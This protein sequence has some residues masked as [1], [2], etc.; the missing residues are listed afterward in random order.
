MTK[1]RT[2]SSRALRCIFVLASWSFFGYWPAQIVAAIICL[3][4]GGLAEGV[5]IYPYDPPVTNVEDAIIIMSPF[6]PAAAAI[7]YDKKLRDDVSFCL[8]STRFSTVGVSTI[9]FLYAYGLLCG[10]FN[11]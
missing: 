2:K 8:G 9:L 10:F 3:F 6:L 5:G 1:P 11:S 4:I 7:K